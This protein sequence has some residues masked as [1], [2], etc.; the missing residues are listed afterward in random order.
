MGDLRIPIPG[1]GVGEGDTFVGVPGGELDIPITPDDE[2]EETG[3]V[4]E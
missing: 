1:A 3:E 4:P 2:E